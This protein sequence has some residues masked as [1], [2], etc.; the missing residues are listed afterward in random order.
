MSH[1]IDPYAIIVTQ[2]KPTGFNTSM[3]KSIGQFL[4]IETASGIL[5]MTA[6]ILALILANSPLSTFYSTFFNEPF[7]FNYNGYHFQKPLIFWINECLM[8][9]FF[10]LIGLEVKREFIEGHLA[11]ASQRILPIIAT[12]GGVIFPAL[13]YVL[14]NYNEPN[15]LRGW[16]IPTATDIAFA[17]G[18]LSLFG[19]KIPKDLRIF[20]LT[21]AVLDD[22][23]AVIIIAF[24][25][26]SK[27]SLFFLALCALSFILLTLLN[28]LGIKKLLPYI[29]LSLFLWFFVLLSGVHPTVAGVLAAFTIPLGNSFNNS[30]RPLETLEKTLHPFVAFLI[31]PLFA[32]ANA[33]ISFFGLNFKTLSDPLPLGIIFGLFLGKQLG[34]FLGTLLPVN[35]KLAKLPNKINWGHIYGISILCGIGFT[36]SLFMGTLAFQNDN[37]NKMLFLKIGV[38]IGSLLSFIYGYFVLKLVLSRQ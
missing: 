18:V 20:L 38:L 3:L 36:M 35:M 26:S 34:I 37:L 2:A 8:V 28:S 31:L 1:Q 23:S 25:Y 33:G 10:F 27:I 6:S 17:L 13:I 32:F 15:N 14:I 5:L 30:Y 11:I 4:K 21:I 29:V 24:F 19:K 7:G 16:A 9:L 12:L 22:L